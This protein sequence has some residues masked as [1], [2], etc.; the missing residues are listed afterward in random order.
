MDEK[1]EAQIISAARKL[2]TLEE[3]F[4]SVKSFISDRKKE[5]EASVAEKKEE[6]SRLAEEIEKAKE[7]VEPIIIEVFNDLKQKKFPGG[8]GV[9]ERTYVQYELEEAFNW[10]KEAKLCLSLDT[11]AFEKVAPS[12]ELPF[13]KT[14]KNPCV[15]YPKTYKLDE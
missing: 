3:E 8:F 6:Q 5:F 4:S 7:E 10:A 11:K 1:I 13:V 2:S 12:L 9:Q 15:T 14:G